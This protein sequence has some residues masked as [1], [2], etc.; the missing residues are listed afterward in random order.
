[1]KVI[2]A[3][4]SELPARFFEEISAIPRASLQEGAIA[5]YLERFAAAR[6][7]YCYRDEA[8]NLLIK[9]QGSAG[10]EGEP[11]L[12]LQAH[13]DMVTEVA[14]GK[15]HDFSKTGVKLIREDNI[16]RAD[17]TTLGADDGFGVA[18]MLAA[19]DGAADSHPPLECLFTSA[20]EIG[21]I[22]AGAFD[23]SRISAR[24]MLNFDSAEEHLVIT[25]CCGGVRS[26]VRI[27]VTLR[28]F[29]GQGLRIGLHGLCG[30]HSGEDIHRGRANVFVTLGKLLAGLYEKTPFRLVSINGG[31]KDNAIPRDGEA[32][33]L[34]VDISAA[35]AYFADAE[36]LLST[37]VTSPDDKARSL[38]VSEILVGEAM[39]K[40]DTESIL[41]FLSIRN[42][43]I[44][45][46]SDIAGMPETSR[47]LASVHTGNSEIKVCFSSRSPFDAKLDELMAELEQAAAALGG[48][49]SHRSRY[50]GWE[51]IPDS[52]V[53]SLWQRAYRQVTGREIS[54]T[55]IHAG[56]ECGLISS[57]LSGLEVISV[58]CNIHDLHTPVETVELDSFERVYQTFLS[59][60]QQC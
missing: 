15:A 43:V 52:P 31:D 2:D 12:L 49:A 11:P 48:S 50:P 13:T 8:N 26:D 39:T 10:R 5:D 57:K 22:G 24:R 3:Y 44:A 60:L 17:G 23:Y 36:A 29:V 28:P 47:N 6:G 34:P 25:G 56:L 55:V 45:F 18:M 51:G 41:D 21:L 40:K 38:S 1:M 33:I 37:L 35:H 32:V 58:G 19:L 54:T 30:G 14:F 27:P 59:F 20:E 46:R 4:L 53:S 16:L 9:K 42:G 7:L